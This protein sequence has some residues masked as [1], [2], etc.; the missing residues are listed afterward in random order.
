MWHA[1]FLDFF[2]C[3]FPGFF[4][5]PPTLYRCWKTILDFQRQKQVSLSSFRPLTG[6]ET[7]LK[8]SAWIASRETL[9]ATTFNPPLFS[10]FNTFKLAIADPHHVRTDP[11]PASHIDAY[12]YRYANN[13]ADPAF[14]I[15]K[16]NFY[17]FER[18]LFTDLPY[19]VVY[20]MT[21]SPIQSFCNCSL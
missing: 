8:I 1:S 6:W 21:C 15:A 20:V 17:L 7:C 12:R 5:K 11:Y 4:P 3:K 14:P 18:H 13:Y 2:Q 9:N 19:I 16:L 10:L